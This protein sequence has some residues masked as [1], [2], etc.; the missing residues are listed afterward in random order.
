MEEQWI[1]LVLWLIEHHPESPLTGDMTAAIFPR[2]LGPHHPGHPAA[3]ADASRL[4]REQVNEHPQDPRVLGNAAYALGAGSIWDEVDLMERA[5]ALA[6]EKWTKPLVHLYAYVLVEDGE[7]G[8]TQN[9]FGN[10]FRNPGL[11]AQIR[12]DLQTSNDIQLVGMTAFN[13]VELAVRKS[14]G[15]E[16][17]SW[18]FAVLRTT[19]QE[20][21]S[22]AE[23]LDP[24][25]QHVVEVLGGSDGRWSDL[26]EGVKGLPGVPVQKSSPLAAAPPST[27]PQMVRISSGVAASLLQQAPGAI[28]PALAKVAGVQGTVKLQVQ[29]GS[30]G[31]VEQIK[32]LSGHP[33]LAPAAIDA[34]K[35]Y[36]YKPFTLNGTAVDAVTTVEVIFALP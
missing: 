17:G 20:L 1:P 29:I 32:I 26:M 14:T 35:G 3:Y 8:P 18:D 13:V 25:N 28:Y 11:A 21:V 30:G 27:S 6:P 24:Q 15:H 4:W 33:L 31:H 5:Q 2:D 19:A 7:V 23:T 16:G 10:P 34:V 9:V 36:V 12:R 22:R